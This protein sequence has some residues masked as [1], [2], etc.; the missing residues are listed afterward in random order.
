MSGCLSQTEPGRVLVGRFGRFGR[1]VMMDGGSQPERGLESEGWA[2][3][4]AGVRGLEGLSNCRA[5]LVG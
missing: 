4:N 2:G 5:W 1:W 3:L